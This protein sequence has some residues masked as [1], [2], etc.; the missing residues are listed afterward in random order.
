MA[1]PNIP[2]MTQSLQNIA[3]EIEKFAN[4]LPLDLQ[5]QIEALQQA[6]APLAALPQQVAQIE[7]QVNQMQVQLD[8]VQGQLGQVQGQLDQVQGQFDQVQGQLTT[9]EK[10]IWVLCYLNFECLDFNFLKMAN[11]ANQLQSIYAIETSLTSSDLSSVVEPTQWG[12]DG[13]NFKG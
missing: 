4:I 3:Q 2:L 7:G 10:S 9:I 1:Q 8:Q 11:T 6:F 13:G 12:A 5:A